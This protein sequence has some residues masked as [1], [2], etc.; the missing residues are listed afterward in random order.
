MPAYVFDLETVVADAGQQQSAADALQAAVLMHEFVRRID[1]EDAAEHAGGQYPGQLAERT[2][3]QQRE[4][5]PS[6]VR[7]VV[8]TV[9]APAN[10]GNRVILCRL[11]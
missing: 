7:L 6:D 9:L 2:E 5:L 1:R 4:L 10:S 3:R 11:H 8:L